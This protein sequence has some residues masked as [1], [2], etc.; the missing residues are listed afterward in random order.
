MPT[1]D[2]TYTPELAALIC[3]RLASGDTLRAICRDIKSPALSTILNWVKDDVQGFADQYARAREVGY[4]LMA[5]ELLEIS[6]DGTNDWIEI[7][8]QDNPGYRLNGEHVQRSRLRVDTRKW[9][10]SKALPKIYGN[11]PIDNGEDEP[12]L[13]NRPEGL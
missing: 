1:G 5:E 11:R 13:I 9:L 10:L 4:W 6:D 2:E 8:N 7:N 12:N 3:N